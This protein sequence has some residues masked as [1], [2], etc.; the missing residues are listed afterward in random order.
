MADPYEA[1]RTAFRIRLRALREERNWS[2]GDA[3]RV[4]GVTGS[5]WRKYEAG[6]V[7]PKLTQ[8]LRIQRAFG[9]AS[10]ELLF[11]ALPTEGL[12]REDVDS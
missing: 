7:E 3:E 4:S 5:Q 8:L 2:L 10:V 12:L 9:F 6:Q 11:G 1:A